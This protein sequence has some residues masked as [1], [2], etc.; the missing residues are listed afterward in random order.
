MSL[1]TNIS[2]S[3]GAQLPAIV[4]SITEIGQAV[5]D[6]G[7]TTFFTVATAGVYRLSG[8]VIMRTLSSSAWTLES[9]MHLPGGVNI[10]GQFAPNLINGATGAYTTNQVSMTLY[11]HVGD[12]I[13]YGTFTT[14]GSNTG[15][16]F[17][18]C[19]TVEQL[20]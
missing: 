8:S 11:L 3:H 4:A 7:Y 5:Q 10:S 17:D 14:S 12:Q 13:G 1:E 15:G 20:A 2:T 6:G 18:A 16:T 19:Y 9:A